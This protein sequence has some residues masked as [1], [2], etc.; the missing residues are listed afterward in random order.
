M[1]KLCASSPPTSLKL[2][3]WLEP[4]DIKVAESFFP[5]SFPFHPFCHVDNWII[6]SACFHHYHFIYVAHFLLTGDIIVNSHISCCYLSFL[7][8]HHLS[9]FFLKSSTLFTDLHSLLFQSLHDPTCHHSSL[10]L[11]HAFCGSFYTILIINWWFCSHVYL[12]S[13]GWWQELNIA[14]SNSTVN[15]DDIKERIEKELILLQWQLSWFWKIQSYWFGFF[16]SLA[17]QTYRNL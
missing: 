16:H 3:P 10:P 2:S 17:Y 4:L 6:L 8:C 1:S 7:S 14:P 13:F 11:V 5:F 15:I 12:C 9:L